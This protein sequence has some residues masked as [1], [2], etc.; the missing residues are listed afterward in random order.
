MLKIKD[1]VDLKELEKYGYNNKYNDDGSYEKVIG[2]GKTIW[3]DNDDKTIW[4]ESGMSATEDEKILE[5]LLDDL[6]KDG[7]VEEAIEDIISVDDILEHIMSF[8]Y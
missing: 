6:I 8:Y 1:N 7:L 5:P 4:L 3:V 2:Y